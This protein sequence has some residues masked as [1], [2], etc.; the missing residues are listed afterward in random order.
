MSQQS[1]RNASS[2]NEGTLYKS[3]LKNLIPWALAGYVSASILVREGLLGLKMYPV[4]SEDPFR[5]ISG[6]APLVVAGLIFVGITA[7]IAMNAN[8]RVGITDR[9]LLYRQGHG[10]AVKLPWGKLSIQTPFV[11]NPGM[12]SRASVTDGKKTI[13]IEKF[14]FPDFI[15]IC[16]ALKDAR[17]AARVRDSENE[18]SS[19][20]NEAIKASFGVRSKK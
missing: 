5:Y 11:K 6:Y 17:N 16:H 4:E 18:T 3:S 8:R 7:L 19:R 10:K 9:F 13:T 15:D 12:L 2:A 14:F 20:G 1:S